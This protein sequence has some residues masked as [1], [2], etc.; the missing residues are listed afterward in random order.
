MPVIDIKDYATPALQRAMKKADDL[1]PVMA[2]I[3][4][5]VLKPLRVSKWAASG[6]HSRS[7]AL[8]SAVSTWHGKKSAGVSVKAKRGR[9]DKG[10]VFAKTAIHTRGAKKGS[11]K[12]GFHRSKKSSRK[13][14][15]ITGK[16]RLSPFG[17][18]PARPFIPED[19]D[20]GRHNGKIAELIKEYFGDV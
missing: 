17:D 1:S 11:F 2:Q 6:L 9:A 12:Q 7:G 10:L 8:F 18:I 13:L 4:A 20:V 15:W 16:K 3:E 14:T 5:N 19:D